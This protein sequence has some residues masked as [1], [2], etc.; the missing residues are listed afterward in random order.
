MLLMLLGVAIFLV[1]LMLGMSSSTC[2]HNSSRKMEKTNKERQNDT[3][4]KN[5]QKFRCKSF[6]RMRV[7]LAARQAGKTRLA[8]A[9]SSNRRS[10]QQRRSQR[11]HYGSL[12]H[13]NRIRHRQRYKEKLI[14][15][16][17]LP[18]TAI[19]CL[20]S[21]TKLQVWGFSQSTTFSSRRTTG[22]ATATDNDSS[23]SLTKW[24]YRTGG[25]SQKWTAKSSHTTVAKQ[26]AWAAGCQPAFGSGKSTLDPATAMLAT[27]PL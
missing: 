11:L 1:S 20:A 23:A 5:R 21:Y 12:G 25:N 15:T 24:N 27:F 9:H 2:N 4:D 17:H 3:F 6:T 18:A 7:A 16:I 14:R 22:F 8:A 13:P 10:A 19:S 26:R